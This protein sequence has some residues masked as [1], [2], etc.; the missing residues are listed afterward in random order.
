MIANQRLV[1]EQQY[2][3]MMRELEQGTPDVNQNQLNIRNQQLSG[4]SSD[5]SQ[6]DTNSLNQ[7]SHTSEQTIIGKIEIPKISIK[8]VI[9]DHAT[10]KNLELSISRFMGPDIHKVGHLVLAGHNMRDGSF[11]GKLRWLERGDIF[12]L[13]DRKGT[14]AF[15]QIEKKYTVRANDLSPVQ[16]TGIFEPVVTLITCDNDDN[17]RLILFANKMP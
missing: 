15:Y 3:L 13:T 9:L 7:T 6:M 11:F 10:D 5:Y 2:E 14:S 17:Y 4:S 12:T 8:Y 16:L 1:L